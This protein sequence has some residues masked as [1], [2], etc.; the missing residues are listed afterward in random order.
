[1]VTFSRTGALKTE[2]NSLMYCKQRGDVSGA[3]T[4]QGFLSSATSSVG[5]SSGGGVA[6]GTQN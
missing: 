2:K 5:G 4:L 3:K 6:F 1:M